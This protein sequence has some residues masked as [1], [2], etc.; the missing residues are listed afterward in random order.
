MLL[1]DLFVRLDDGWRENDACSYER[2]DAYLGRTLTRRTFD[3]RTKT[4][5]G[6]KWATSTF[7]HLSERRLFKNVIRF[8]FPF[9]FFFA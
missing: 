8:F 4:F 9:F 6:S 2:R 1:G 5:Q 3:S 7:S